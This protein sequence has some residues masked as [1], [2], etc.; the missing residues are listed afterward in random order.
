M[1]R[2]RL[3]ILPTRRHLYTSVNKIT[4]LH[5]TWT[6]PSLDKIL[7]LTFKMIKL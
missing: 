3:T 4:I 6:C 7:V 1:P 2:A 5:S